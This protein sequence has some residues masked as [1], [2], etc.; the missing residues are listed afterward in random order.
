MDTQVP[1][2]IKFEVVSSLGKKIRT[3]HEYWRKIV[4]TKHPGMAKHEDLVKQ[5][6]T[7]PQEVRRSKKDRA[8]HL[9]Y[10]KSNSHY[11]CV[12]AKHLIGDGFVVTAY[13]TSVIRVGEPL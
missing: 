4:T 8:V 12:V 5:T 11:C 3:S 2:P 7:D 6:L 13:L 10:R 1:D 9:Y